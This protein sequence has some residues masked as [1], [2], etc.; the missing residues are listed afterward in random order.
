MVTA[1]TEYEMKLVIDGELLL[2]KNK[3]IQKVCALFGG[4]NVLYQEIV[5]SENLSRE[6]FKG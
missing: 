5:I 4:L 6:N 2:S 1:L 3:V